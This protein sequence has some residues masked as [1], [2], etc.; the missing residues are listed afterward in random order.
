MPI[1]EYYCPA[2]HVIFNFFARTMTVTQQPTCPRCKKQELSRQVSM[3]AVTGPGGDSAEPPLPANDQRME[4]AIAS[5]A[6]EA[7]SMNP[8]DPRQAADLM[9]R[10]SNMTGMKFGEGVEEA[11]G[12]LEAGEDPDKIEQ[13]L[14][15][16]L[17]DEDVLLAGEGKEGAGAG[18]G[19]GMPE[20]DPTLYDL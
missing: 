7:E 19:K 8:D 13:E 5:L 10:F 4:Q 17:E 1:Y 16:Q 12:R 18:G 9:R 20:R 6:G 2:C 11:L 14:G 3:F 15:D